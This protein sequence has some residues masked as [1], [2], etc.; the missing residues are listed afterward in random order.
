MNFHHKPLEKYGIYTKSTQLEGAGVH[1]TAHSLIT[2]TN[3]ANKGHTHNHNFTSPQSHLQ[4]R[5]ASHT[6]KV[7]VFPLTLLGLK[8]QTPQIA[9][10]TSLLVCLSAGSL[11]HVVKPNQAAVWPPGDYGSSTQPEK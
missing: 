6:H 2:Y 5:S 7:T 10:I 9:I 1:A 4:P 3:P 11:L 8:P